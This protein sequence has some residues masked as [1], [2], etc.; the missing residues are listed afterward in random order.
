VLRAYDADGRIHTGELASPEELDA[1]LEK[2]L[3]DEQVAEVQV[4][5][6]SHGCF[7]FAVTRD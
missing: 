3:A 5:S 1:V 2:L 4:R 7:L 6:L